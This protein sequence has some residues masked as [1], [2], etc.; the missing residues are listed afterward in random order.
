ML[1][2]EFNK[3]SETWKQRPLAYE[4]HSWSGQSLHILCWITWKWRPPVNKDH[5]FLVPRVVFV[6]RFHC[7]SHMFF[8]IGSWRNNGTWH[9]WQSAQSW[10]NCTEQCAGFHSPPHL[11]HSV[12]WWGKYHGGHWGH[13]GGDVRQVLGWPADAAKWQSQNGGCL[14]SIQ[15]VSCTIFLL[16]W[17]RADLVHIRFGHVIVYIQNCDWMLP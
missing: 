10:T 11:H 8:P 12:F 6:S 3:Y 4:D 5:I 15:K 17:L 14:Q 9:Y 1:G 13:Q 2:F 16:I 7:I